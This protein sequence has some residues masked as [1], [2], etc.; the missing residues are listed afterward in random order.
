MLLEL[1]GDGVQIRAWLGLQQG[2]A[3]AALL[4]LQ[5][6]AARQ[7]LGLIVIGL[8]QQGATDGQLRAGDPLQQ[9]VA[10]AQGLLWH[11]A[12]QTAGDPFLAAVIRR[13]VGFAIHLYGVVLLAIDHHRFVGRCVHADRGQQA[14]Q[15]KAE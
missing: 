8:H 14:C 5:A 4:E 2:D 12:I 1:G 3:A 7:C 15:G 6:V 11:L 9:D 13:Q 10:A